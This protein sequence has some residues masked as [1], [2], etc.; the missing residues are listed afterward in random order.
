MTDSPARREEGAAML[1]SYRNIST[2]VS[3]ECF[4]ACDLRSGSP[5][6]VAGMAYVPSTPFTLLVSAA[7]HPA[8]R[9]TGIYTGLFCARNER[10][11]AAGNA[12][13][14][15]QVVASTSAPITLAAGFEK[16]CE[17]DRWL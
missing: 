13:L 2:V 9:R 11:H 5:A 7:T 6:G 16:R 1:S 8:S 10:A 12:S 15:T 3:T 17:V 14:I 4:V